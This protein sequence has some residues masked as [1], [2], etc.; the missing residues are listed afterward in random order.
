MGRRKERRRKINERCSKV[1]KKKREDEREE[2]VK[3]VKKTRERNLARK[4]G[5]EKQGKEKTVMK[6]LRKEEETG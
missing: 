5:K 2:R 4:G 3:R 1:S 6:T